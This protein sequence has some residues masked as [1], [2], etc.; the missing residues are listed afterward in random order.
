MGDHES[1][2]DLGPAGAVGHHG[3][4]NADFF[5]NE[6][7]IRPAVG[8]QVFV[9]GDTPDVT[10]PAWQN[11]QHRLAPLQ[12]R[13]RGEVPQDL[14][15]HFIAH[16]DGNFLQI[17]QCIHHRQRHLGGALYLD[18][19]AGRHGVEP[20]HPA[21][22]ACGC[23]KLAFITA[24]NPEL[25]GL[26]AENLTDKGPCAHRT[27]IG[28]YHTDHI[29]NGVGWQACADGA[30][31][32]QGGRG[33]H[34]RVNSEIRI[35]HRT[36]LP[37]QQDA[38]PLRLSLTEELEG[39]CHIGGDGVPLLPE[40]VKHLL[41]RQPGLM[42]QVLQGDI[43]HF[44]DALQ[45]IQRIGVVKKLRQ[46]E[47]DFCIFIR[48]EGGNA[49]LGRAKGPPAQARL[50]V[51]IKEHMIGH[52]HLNPVR[53]Q[54]LRPYASRFQGGNLLEEL[55]Q[56]QRDTVA[57]DVGHMGIKHTGGQLVQSKAAMLIDNGMP[58]IAATLEPDDHIGIPGQNIC[59]LAFSLVAPIGAYNRFYHTSSSKLDHIASADSAALPN[60][61]ASHTPTHTRH[62]ITD[63][64]HK[65]NSICNSL[66]IF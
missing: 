14:A 62:S 65:C 13:R 38:L 45:L 4:G 48:I 37:F 66:F 27:G 64:S 26:I 21:G 58:G 20:A 50:L 61:A 63:T 42:V 32:C 56:V 23:A 24:P 39:V 12:G 19:V 35:L 33:S 5:L 54:Q 52:H 30:V 40:A 8:R 3:N 47:A 1:I 7:H 2:D 36:Q 18:P 41:R 53:D 49:R 22:P 28:L 59:N 16:A 57:D 46:L 31:A 29:R 60:L 34:H 43:L 6:L 51:L 15:V 11:L 55:T 25:L 17:P 10:I 9:P 44:Q